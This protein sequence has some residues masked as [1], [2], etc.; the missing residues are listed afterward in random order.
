MNLNFARSHRTWKLRTWSRNYAKHR[1]KL[2][3]FRLKNCSPRRK[4]N[5]KNIHENLSWCVLLQIAASRY[6]R[7]YFIFISNRLR[8]KVADKNKGFSLPRIIDE[9]FMHYKKLNSCRVID[10]ARLVAMR[11]GLSLSNVMNK[12]LRRSISCWPRLWLVFVHRQSLSCREMWKQ[13]SFNCYLC[14][15]LFQFI[16]FAFRVN[17]L[18]VHWIYLF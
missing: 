5:Q 9:P 17:L 2:E 16:R 18:P 7:I 15:I 12:W 11:N 3:F 1:R 14:W 4:L 6:I 8:L 10:F 13:N